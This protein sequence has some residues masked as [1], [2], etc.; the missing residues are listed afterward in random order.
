MEH[1]EQI[2]P[3]NLQK[4]QK[5]FK[6][7]ENFVLPLVEITEGCKTESEIEL[8]ALSEFKFKN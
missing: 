4:T 7:G 6:G 8:L 5:L 3:L 1:L 2:I